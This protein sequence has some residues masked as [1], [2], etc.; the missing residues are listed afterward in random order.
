VTANSGAR[1]RSRPSSAKLGEVVRRAVA[2]F[3]ELSG[4]EPEQVS[5]VRSADEGWS[6]LVEVVDVERIPIT[7]SILSTYRI[8]ADRQGALIG[9]ERIRRYSRSATDS[10]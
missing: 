8:D 1:P 2:E 9:Y 4:L 10:H 3:R 7:T 5:G 6:M